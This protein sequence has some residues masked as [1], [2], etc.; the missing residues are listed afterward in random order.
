[1]TGPTGPPGPVGMTGPIGPPG[2]NGVGCTVSKSGAV[3]TVTC[4]SPSTSVQVNDGGSS[5][6]NGQPLA[7][8]SVSSVQRGPSTFNTQPAG[9]ALPINNVQPS[10]GLNYI[11]A[12][13]GIFPPRS[14]RD[15]NGE[16][17]ENQDDPEL[18]K[19][20]SRRRLGFEP[21]IG[22]V[23]LFAGNFAPNSWAF[24]NG[25]FLQIAQNTALFAILG[26]TYGGDGRTTFAL[27]DLRGRVVMGTGTGPGLTGRNLGES[28]G[29]EGTT[30]TTANLASHGHAVPEITRIAGTASV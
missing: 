7:L 21:F 25:Q 27:P 14:R 15:L 6:I 22:E 4:G 5:S 11:I 2:P 20:Q 8:N 16:E 1:M 12:L 19:D 28:L 18:P 29:L 30:L 24:C 3:S 10:L 13:Q 23:S 9:S 17:I 26:T